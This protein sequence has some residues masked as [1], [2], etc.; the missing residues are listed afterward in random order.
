MLSE[1]Y[2]AMLATPLEEESYEAAISLDD[3]TIDFVSIELKLILPYQVLH[4]VNLIAIVLKL[5]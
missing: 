1:Y 3:Q 5:T 2:E 4:L